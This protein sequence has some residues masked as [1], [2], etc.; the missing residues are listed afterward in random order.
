[1]IKKLFLIAVFLLITCSALPVH[2]QYTHVW[3]YT[4]A[5]ATP[6]SEKL[7]TLGTESE[8]NIFVPVMGISISQVT[9]NFGDPRPGGR[10][11]E[12]LDIMAPSGTV[13]I[14]PTDAVVIRTGYGASAGYYVYTANPGGETF[15]Y[16]HLKEA[17]TRTVGDI[18]KPGDNI[19]LVGNTGNASGGLSHLHFE[20]RDSAFKAL[21][22]YTRLTKEFTQEAVVEENTTFTET[23]DSENSFPI[24]SLSQINLTLKARG[25]DV[26]TLQKFLM[27]KNSGPAAEALT[28]ANP[29]GYFGNVTK[30]ALAEYQKKSGIAPASGYYGPKT[31]AYIAEY[32]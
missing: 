9:K 14:S 3:S 23:N 2:A 16:M 5:L 8:Q 31:R 6:L 28:K 21:D 15:V 17:S 12:G 25:S 26:L 32:E 18:V 19:G 24:E 1:M 13:I 22:P 29:N 27:H 11:H 30:L 20:I 10:V 4:S 7:A